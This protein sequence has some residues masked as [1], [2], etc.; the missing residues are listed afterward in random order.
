MAPAPSRFNCVLGQPQDRYHDKGS[1]FDTELISVIRRAILALTQKAPAAGQSAGTVPETAGE[2]APTS[3]PRRPEAVLIEAR[4]PPEE[5]FC[6]PSNASQSFREGLPEPS[7]RRPLPTQAANGTMPAQPCHSPA[8]P[9]SADN[10][11]QPAHSS[12]ARAPTRKP[13]RP[14]PPSPSTSSS[15]ATPA[16]NSPSSSPCAPC[17]ASSTGTVLHA[18]LEVKKQ[19][20]FQPRWPQ[21]FSRAY[22]NPVPLTVELGKRGI[23]LGETW[24]KMCCPCE[25]FLTVLLRPYA[26]TPGQP[27]PKEVKRW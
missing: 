5:P 12:S 6:Q 17:S 7:W 19:G 14:S 16:S 9:P 24:T 23:G 4:G 21:G 27:A 26:R 3:A 10:S 25:F 18:V 1:D 15:S 11:A 20:R 2:E 8:T 13:P 22:A